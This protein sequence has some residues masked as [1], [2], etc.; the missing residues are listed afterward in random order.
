[1]GT[2]TFKK[3]E[4]ENTSMTNEESLLIIQKMINQAKVNFKQSSFHLLF[5]GWLIMITSLSNFIMLKFTDVQ[6]PEFVWF[7]VFPGIVVSFVYG[8]VNGRRNKV[9]TYAESIYSWVWIG[10]VITFFLISYFISFSPILISSMSLV[11]A[12][13]ATFISGN[14]LKF[15]PLIAGGI[16]FWVGSIVA[17]LLS[18]EYALLIS[19]V[20]VL[21]GY[22][23]PGHLL[24]NKVQDVTF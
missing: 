21:T 6:H 7:S 2:S 17:F 3:I 20:S 8:F 12:G 13:Y 9:T 1:M 11:L 19:S 10:F 5:W 22:I 4:M 23:I 18:N 24:R 14:I 15:K 16:L